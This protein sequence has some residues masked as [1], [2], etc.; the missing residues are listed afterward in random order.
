[1]FNLTGMKKTLNITELAKH[2]GINKRTLYNMIRDGR[3]PVEPI[4]NGT[5][6]LWSVEMVDNWLRGQL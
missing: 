4:T 2:T 3:F 6:R 5:P 1:M